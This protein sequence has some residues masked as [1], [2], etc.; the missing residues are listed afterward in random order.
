MPSFIHTSDWQLGM[1]RRFLN[2]EAQARYS[3]ARIDVIR[4]IGQLAAARNCAFIAVAGDVFEY[5][6]MDRVTVARALEAMGEAGVPVV[7]LP[8]N[9]DPCGDDSVY[10][11]RQFAERKQNNIITIFDSTPIR[12]ADDL[13]VLGAPWPSKHPVGNP[14]IRALDEVDPPAAGVFRVCLAHGYVDI[15]SFSEDAEALIPFDMLRQ[16]IAE[17]KIHYAALGDR[18]SSD[19]LDS[20]SGRIRYSGTPE[21]TDFDEIKPGHV[22]LVEL[23]RD[24]VVVEECRVGKW[25]FTKLERQLSGLDDVMNIMHE[26]ERIPDKERTIVRLDVTGVLG[27]SD[28]KVLRDGLDELSLTFA[29]IDLREIDYV[30][31][32]GD[33]RDLCAH[34]GGYAAET[35][36]T[37]RE[38]IAEGGERGRIAGDALLLL[39]RLAP[40]GED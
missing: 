31:Q 35:A 20:P 19:V 39:D 8:G 23:S 21:Q 10:R 11:G 16:A 7:L 40:A 27:L 4:A 9:H 17:G 22:S 26:L 5:E 14:V 25:T 1:T 36:E 6:Q 12:I 34:L 28:D 32:A 15:R 2:P 3:Q 30:I 18:H 37:L 38:M 29:G 13:E 33:S 24:G